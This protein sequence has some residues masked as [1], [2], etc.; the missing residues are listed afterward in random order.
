MSKKRVL[1]VDDEQHI[2]DLLKLFVEQN[3]CVAETA[4]TAESGLVKARIG[5]YDMVLL[6]INLPDGNGLDLLKKIKDITPQTPIIMITGGGDMEVGKECIEH[7][8]SD[9]IAKP[10]DFDYLETSILVNFLGF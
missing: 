2:L 8:A 6:D 1:I 10:I 4:N 9:Y 5:Q 7:G 3:N